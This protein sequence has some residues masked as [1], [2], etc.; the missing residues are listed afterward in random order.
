MTL[1]LLFYSN[2][3]FSSILL[4]LILVVHFVHYKSFNFV[5]SENFVQFHRFHTKSISF[6]VIPLMV[7]EVLVSIILCY[8]YFSI[9][10]LVNLLLVALI[11]IVTFLFQ[12]PSHNKLSNYKSTIEIKKLVSRN[13]YR[14][15]L[16]LSKVIIATLI[17]L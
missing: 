15:Y 8:F 11:W 2:L 7:A 12:V 4:G 9:L 5:D 14:V 13:I 6:L 10:S 16:W 17:I 1:A 3:I